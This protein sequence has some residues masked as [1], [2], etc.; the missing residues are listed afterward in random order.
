[1]ILCLSR[2]YVIASTIAYNVTSLRLTK[3]TK[4]KNVQCQSR[5]RA[6]GPYL[7]P[8]VNVTWLNM[9]LHPKLVI[10]PNFD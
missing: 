6:K 10:E 7:F 8:D 1:M 2:W 3:N 4:K 5:Y 9:E